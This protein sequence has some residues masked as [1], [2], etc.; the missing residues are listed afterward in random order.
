MEDCL[1]SWQTSLM[2]PGYLSDLSP[3]PTPKGHTKQILALP[4]D[5]GR[6]CSCFL[7]WSQRHHHSS[8]PTLSGSHMTYSKDSLSSPYP[9][10]FSHH[11]SLP[12]MIFTA[13]LLPALEGEPHEDSVYCCPPAPSSTRYVRNI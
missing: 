10:L 6:C 4:Q 5:L 3:L 13:C 1:L 2:N 9:Y 11:L 12:N 7:E 8:A